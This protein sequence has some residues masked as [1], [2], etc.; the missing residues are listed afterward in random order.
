[1]VSNFMDDQ[2]RQLASRIA[3]H[4]AADAAAGA[5]RRARAQAGAP[6]S[7]RSGA[8]TAQ[9]L[10]TLVA[11]SWRSPLQ[12]QPG[13][14][15]VRMASGQRWRVYTAAGAAPTAQR[16]Q[17]LQSGD[18]RATLAAER[19]GAALAPMLI[20]LPLAIL[21]LWG[22]VARDVARA[23]GHRPAGGA[24]GRAQ[25]RRAAADARAAR[26]SRRWS[27]SFNSLLARL[28]DAFATQRRFVQDAA[29]ELRTPIT[30]HRRCSWKTCAPTC[31]R[32]RAESFAPARSRR[33]A[34][35]SA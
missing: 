7:S 33:A 29:H 8:P 27:T 17:V 18:F 28:R 1:M 2:M 9:L 3:A 12:P 35:R 10:A 21:V 19:A 4:D 15:D 25:H 32:A 20:L 31:R 24:A 14:R 22:V 16:V 26:R 5:E 23:A 34:A 13:F 6:T 30:A 11:R